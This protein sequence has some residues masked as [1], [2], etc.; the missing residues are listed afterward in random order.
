MAL[1][2]SPG[3]SIG[4]V[5]VPAG[6]LV[7]N[8]S[9]TTHRDPEIF[10]DPLDFKPARWEHATPEMKAMHRPFS[11]GPRNCLGMHMARVQVFLTVSALY[12]RFDLKLDPFVKEEDMALR[13]VGLMGPI[14]Q[15]LKM[16]VTPRV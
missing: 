1:R 15:T 14:G 9:Y 4:G 6:T 16:Y 8:L 13:D 11:T 12:Q 3:K 2:V 5:Y 7:S 10:P